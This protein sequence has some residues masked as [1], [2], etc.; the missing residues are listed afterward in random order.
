[1]EGYELKEHFVKKFPVDSDRVHPQKW[2]MKSFKK[3]VKVEIVKSDDLEIEFDLIGVPACFANAFRR[4]LLAEVPMMAIE[5][6][7]VYNNTSILQDEVLAHRL[8]LIP[9]KADPRKFAFKK[10]EDDEFSAEDSLEYHLRIKCSKNPKAPASKS[11]DVSVSQYKND[12][13]LSKDIEWVPIGDQA[14]NFKSSD[15][16][17]VNDDI[18]IAK[19]RPGHELDVKLFA[20]KGIGKDHAK[21]QPVATASFRLLPEITLLTE[22]EGE[23]AQR[24]K[25]SF[26]DGVIELRKHKGKIKA[27]VVNARYDSCSRNVFRF[28]DLKDCVKISRV[29]DHYIFTIESVGALPPNTLFLEAIKVL[30]SKCDTILNEIKAKGDAA[31][32]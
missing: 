11:G 15:V 4:V 3:I 27:Q 30:K 32:S 25:S 5:K 19:L 24:L 26:S 17:P 22:V 21:F 20:V 1:M 12:K 2:N 28:D 9:L 31:F 16:G 13:V 6:V 10:S 7:H 23:Q 18:L 8:G 14:T 29:P